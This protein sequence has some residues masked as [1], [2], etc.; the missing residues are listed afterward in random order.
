[1]LSLAFIKE[2]AR[3]LIGRV[4]ISD[5]LLR[6]PTT[7]CYLPKSTS[8]SYGAAEDRKEHSCDDE[9]LLGNEKSCLEVV[10]YKP[11]FPDEVK[12]TWLEEKR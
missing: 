5:W 12:C 2:F 1:M 4:R 9:R 8:V 7:L 6:L 11:L 3:A 10:V